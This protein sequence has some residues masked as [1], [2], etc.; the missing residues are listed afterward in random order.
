MSQDRSPVDV[1]LF[2]CSRWVVVESENFC[3]RTVSKTQIWSLWHFFDAL[4]AHDCRLVLDQRHVEGE[5]CHLTCLTCIN[6]YTSIHILLK[7]HVYTCHVH[8]M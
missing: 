4:L 3:P 6:M 8:V 2:V 5:R 1:K 7:Y